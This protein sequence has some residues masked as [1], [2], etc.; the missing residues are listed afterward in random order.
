MKHGLNDNGLS[1]FNSFCYYTH[2]LIGVC[3]FTSSIVNWI[4][5]SHSKSSCLQV[6]ECKN[7]RLII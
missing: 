2:Q 4:S 7:N 1:D 5:I 3:W 6:F